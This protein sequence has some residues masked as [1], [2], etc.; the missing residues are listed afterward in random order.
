[1]TN[2]NL[3]VTIPP[4]QIRNAGNPVFPELRRILRPGPELAA[5]IDDREQ[6]GIAKYGQT[7]L[8]DDS[9]DPPTEIVNELLDAL[10]YLTKWQMQHENSHGTIDDA[11]HDTADILRNVIALAHEVQP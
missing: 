11:I 4:T 2:T 9:R 7:L 10:A 6:Y 1:M 3:A 5:L 8:T